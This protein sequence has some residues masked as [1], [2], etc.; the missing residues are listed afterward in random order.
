VVTQEDVDGLAL[1]SD[2]ARIM[3]IS[4]GHFLPK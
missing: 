3:I 1:D 2:M 4:G